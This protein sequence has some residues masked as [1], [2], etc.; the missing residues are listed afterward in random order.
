MPSP[1]GPDEQPPDNELDEQGD[2]N[3]SDAPDETEQAENDN[4]THPIKDDS[5][6]VLQGHTSETL[7]VAASPSNPA[8]IITGSMDDTGLIWDLE[9]QKSLAKV[10]GAKDSISAVA[11]SH[12]GSYAAFASENGALSVVFMS[13]REAPPAVLDG[14]GDTINFLSW[15]P[16]GPVLL[17]GSS[18]SVAYMW[19]VPKGKFMMAFAGHEDS[20][21]CGGFTGDG[22]FVVTG[23]L[24]SAVRVWSPSSGQT[25]VR[26]QTGMDGIKAAFHSADIQT[27][28]VG[29]PNTTSEK[30]I[31]SGCAGGN[32]FITHRETGQ[33]VSQ[34]PRHGGGVESIAFAPATLRQ[35]LVATAG[36]DGTIR[37]WN[38]ENSS[39]RCKFVHGGVIAKVLWHPSKPLLLS[40]SSDGCI[41]VWNVLL[42]VEAVRFTG[43]EAFITDLCLAG[44]HNFIAS[45]S[46]DGTVRIFDLREVLSKTA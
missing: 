23:S 28:S 17:A 26:V 8:L 13:G 1:R 6:L 46:G 42:G 16:R 33:I 19:N 44:E 39:E 20:I 41:V 15:H 5:V 2:I 25:L 24:D 10:D 40:G 30:L 38:V 12:D 34:L 27:L 29:T 9:L 32:V 43:H 45:T 21:T 7:A 35:T 18:D 36:A 31:A 11:F 14:P 4:D 22:K 3:I 37:V